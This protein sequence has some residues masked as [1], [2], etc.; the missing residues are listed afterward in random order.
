MKRTVCILMVGIWALL[1]PAFAD[2]QVAGVWETSFGNLSLA[3]QG[4]AVKGHYPYH[5]GKISGELNRNV[6]T[7]Y[8]LEEGS[9]TC[10][11]AL[12]GYRKWGRFK[13]IFSS[14]GKRF[15]GTWGYCDKTTGGTWSGKLVKAEKKV[16]L[17]A[18]STPSTSKSS[19]VDI[20]SKLF[21]YPTIL[22]D[23]IYW[24]TAR[25]HKCGKV[26]ADNFCHMRGYD[27]AVDF[28]MDPDVGHRYPLRIID[29]ALTCEKAFC[30]SFKYI[31][32]SAKRWHSPGP[33]M[34]IEAG[35]PVQVGKMVPLHLKL[36]HLPQGRINIWWEVDGKISKGWLSPDRKTYKVAPATK[37]PVIVRAHATDSDW[38]MLN[39]TSIKL[40]PGQT[41]SRHTS[42]SAHTT[43]NVPNI[44]GL[45]SKSDFGRIVF[46]QKGRKVKGS[47]DYKNGKIYGTLIGNVLNGYWVQSSSGQRCST[48]KY[49]SYYWGGV[50]FVYKNGKLVGKWGYC[51]KK[52]SAPWSI[53]R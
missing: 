48:P 42:H 15:D 34:H 21:K 52:L 17:P 12:Q 37:Q 6:L 38:N 32:C 30:D 22:G 49:G 31:R 46:A 11:T 24:C 20:G 35:G 40:V 1:R 41:T 19:S 29:T 7:G 2:I 8:W 45:W 25:G 13:F 39:I 51:D 33:V 16:R 23:R 10:P 47:Y 27:H 44:E 9:G 28:A 43:G 26:V 5:N 4:K 14:D 53:Y 36:S 50:R 18:H 3:Q